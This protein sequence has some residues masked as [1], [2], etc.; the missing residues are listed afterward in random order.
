M[1]DKQD[2]RLH[3]HL[4]FILD[5]DTINNGGVSYSNELNDAMKE[6]Q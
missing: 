1:T 2:I 4:I 6:K 5:S 3:K